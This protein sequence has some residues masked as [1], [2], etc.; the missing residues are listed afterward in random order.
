MYKRR[1][2]IQTNAILTI[3]LIYMEQFKLIKISKDTTS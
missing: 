1:Y 2:K 3:I